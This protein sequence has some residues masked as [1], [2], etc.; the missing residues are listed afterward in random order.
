MP[1]AQL[2]KSQLTRKQTIL[3]K[4]EEL[5]ELHQSDVQQN[6]ESPD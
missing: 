2:K 6:E 1:K 5:S 4:K 3:T